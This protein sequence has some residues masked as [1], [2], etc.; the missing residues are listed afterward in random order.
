MDWS[1]LLLPALQNAAFAAVAGTGFALV[2]T[3]SR[4][5]LPLVALLAA[6]G[7]T[8]RFLMQQGVGA[9]ITLASL[10]AALAIGFLSVPLAKRLKCPAELLAFP[11]LLPMIPGMYAYRA[12]LALT[13][14]MTEDLSHGAQLQ[15]AIMA[16]F[17]HGLTTLFVMG[18]LVVGMLIPL[19]LFRRVH[20]TRVAS[21]SDGGKSAGK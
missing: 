11:S 1:S 15:E 4:R 10:V 8:L 12:V 19:H 3:P 14:F 2:S 21:V 6:L 9:N 16:F 5:S 17:H 18:A 20:F 13:Q 7:H